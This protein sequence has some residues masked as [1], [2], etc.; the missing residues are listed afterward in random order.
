ML[1]GLALGGVRGHDVA[2]FDDDG[3]LG[4]GHAGETQAQ[5]A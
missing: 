2:E 5:Q 1:G 4:L 3:L